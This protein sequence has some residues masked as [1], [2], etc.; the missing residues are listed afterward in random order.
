[1]VQAKA[2]LEREWLKVGVEARLG[3]IHEE[4]NAIYA[5]FPELRERW[6]M[7]RTTAAPK[8]TFS[9]RGKQAISDGM[10][11]YWA[12]R[13]AREAKAAKSASRA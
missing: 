10:R 9:E 12:R 3:Q 1:V 13:K 7:M 11:K 2:R 6:P 5:T 4:L 8:R